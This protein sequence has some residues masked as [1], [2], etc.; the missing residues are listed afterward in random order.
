[1]KIYTKTGDKGMTSL[2]G[3]KRVEKDDARVQAYGTLDELQSFVG[4]L[5]SATDEVQLE[6]VQRIL[7]KIGGYLASED[8]TSAGVSDE[9]IARLEQ[10]IDRL[11]EELPPLR[12]FI[13]PDGTMAASICHV[14]RTVYRRAERRMITLRRTVDVGL[15]DNAFIYI[16]RLSD[17]FFLLARKL[18]KVAGKEDVTL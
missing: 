9:T 1:M 15:D 12:T 10:W 18:N 11:S 5:A 4:M 13:I 17:Y 3:G 16:D 2:V 6:D 7:F 14:C 8:A